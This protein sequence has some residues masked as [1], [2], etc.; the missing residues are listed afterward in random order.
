M[1]FNQYFQNTG[2]IIFE[3]VFSIAMN[4]ST[5]IFV[6]RY[7]GPE[8]FGLLSYAISLISL[9][10]IVGHAG[11]SGLVVRELVDKPEHEFKIMGSSFLIKALGYTISAFLTVLFA[12]LYYDESGVMFWIIFSLSIPLTLQAFEVIDYWF[13]SRLEARF[14]SLSRL[15]SIFS[16]SI[17]KLTLIIFSSELIYF[18]IAQ[19]LQSILFALGLI[20]F[21]CVNSAKSISKWKTSKEKAKQLISEGSLVFIG[22]IFAV[23]YLKIDQVMIKW[24]VNSESVGIYAVAASISEAWYFIPTAIVASFSPKL[25]Q[26][27]K[28]SSFQYQYRLQQLFDMLFLLSLIVAI[29]VS[30]I[31]KPLILFTFGSEYIDSSSILVI[32]IWAS[33]FVFMRALLSRWIVIENLLI[34][35]VV[36]QGFG[37]F[38]NVCLNLWLIPK[39][40]GIG[41]AYATLISYAIASYFAL[42]FHAKSRVIFLMMTFAML[43][44]V[45]YPTRYILNKLN[46]EKPN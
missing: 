22:S 27:K 2:W 42:L 5:A 18:A 17:L 13:Q 8:K 45:R 26:L 16:S 15:F 21:Y 35:S 14:S 34:F 1:K 25:I 28:S 4:F 40:G 43:G 33:L 23:I 36:T 9:I 46:H 41:A 7:L 29:L 32:H 24:L 11:L 30:L 37:A 38:S 3:R 12:F 19:A 31:S 20:Y 10:S 44:F 39:F 6:S